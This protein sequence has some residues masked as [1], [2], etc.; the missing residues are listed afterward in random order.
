MKSLI[1]AVLLSIFSLQAFATSITGAEYDSGAEVLTLSLSYRGGLK[2]HEY[3]LEYDSCQSVGGVKEVAARLIDTGHDDTGSQEISQ[4]AQ[5]SLKDLACKP[6][7][8]TVRT[9]RYSF[10]TIWIE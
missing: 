6:A 5:F 1:V 8:L 4:T 9:G 3:S 10:I 7:W 2:T